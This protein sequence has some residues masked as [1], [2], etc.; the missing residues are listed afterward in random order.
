MYSNKVTNSTDAARALES[1]HRGNLRM[2]WVANSILRSSRLNK[3]S[4][5]Q[6]ESSS[7]VVMLILD[8]NIDTEP[9]I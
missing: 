4:Q 8:T 2:L 5:R 7:F 9:Q 6:L 3:I 1:Q